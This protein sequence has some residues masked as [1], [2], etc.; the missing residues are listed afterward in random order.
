MDNEE[1]QQQEQQPIN[2]YPL[3][4]DA[5][6]EPLKVPMGA[7]AWR[8]RRGGGRR[9]RPRIVFDNESGRQL[10]IPIGATI[11]D[12]VDRGCPP[13]RYRLE[14]IDA[15]GHL[16]AGCVAV[17]EVPIETEADDEEEEINNDTKAN[18]LGLLARQ[19][20]TIERQ[21]DTLARALEAAVSGYGE[22]RPAAPT[23]PVVADPRAGQGANA[24]GFKLEQ[25]AQ[26]LPQ[27]LPQLLPAIQF[28]VAAIKNGGAAMP[29]VGMPGA[30]G[31]AAA[32]PANGS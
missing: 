19:Q 29:F 18:L 24:G 2:P 3:A 13:G 23:A 15:S 27:L 28:V 5:N 10:E 14:A 21:S 8:V 9:G 16:I 6:G 4:Y 1:V 31:G 20:A 22:V 11:A 17:T 32:A 30:D 25:L 7:V 26:M 12:L